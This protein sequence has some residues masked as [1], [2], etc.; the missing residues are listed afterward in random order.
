MRDLQGA[1][2]DGTQVFVVRC[3]KVDVVDRRRGGQQGE[4][5]VA[6]VAGAS[7]AFA[8]AAWAASEVSVRTIPRARACARRPV[9]SYLLAL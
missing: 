2:L 9:M 8:V 3:L 7:A 1:L 4:S 6:L 5:G